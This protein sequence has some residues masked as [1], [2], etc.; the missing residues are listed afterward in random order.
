[1]TIKHLGHVDMQHCP[2]LNDEDWLWWSS[3]HK[4][5]AFK[6]HEDVLNIV[7]L[8]FDEKKEGYDKDYTEQFFKPSVD[9]LGKGNAYNITFNMLEAGMEIVPHTDLDPRI[10]ASRRIHIP[11]ITHPDIMFING[12]DKIHMERG[13]AYEIDNTKAH[14]IHNNSDIDR[15]HLVIDWEDINT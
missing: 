14:G 2:T 4:A 6:S 10:R 3:I 15:V 7:L 8:W 12:D 9:K 11:I 13:Y 5:K 1:M